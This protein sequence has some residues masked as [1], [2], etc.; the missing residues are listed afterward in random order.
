MNGRGHFSYL[1]GMPSRCVRSRT[2]SQTR[3]PVSIGLKAG[4]AG[5][6]SF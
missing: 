6:G 3:M 1:R 4:M 2:V 5:L